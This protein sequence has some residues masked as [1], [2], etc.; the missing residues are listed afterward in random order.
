MLLPNSLVIN[1]F[2]VRMVVDMLRFVG[3]DVVIGPYMRHRNRGWAGVVIGPYKRIGR[4]VGTHKAAQNGQF[5]FCADGYEVGT[6]GAVFVF[7][8]AEGFAGGHFT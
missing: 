1:V 2:Q 6:G 8:Q 7:R 5:V 4:S 3:A